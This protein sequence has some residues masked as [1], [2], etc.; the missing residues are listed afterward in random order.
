MN[1][2]DLSAMNFDGGDH[3]YEQVKRRIVTGIRSGEWKVG[4]RLPSEV[5]LVSE[6][7]VS[8]MTINRAYRE[9]AAEGLI[10]RVPAKGSFVAPARAR[11]MLFELRDVADEI[12]V[13]GDEYRCQVVVKEQVAVPGS[14]PT[15]DLKGASFVFHSIV[16]HHR[17]GDPIQ[18]EERWV[19]PYQA[20]EYL[21]I[22]FQ[23]T[24]A[25]QYLSR[26]GTTEMEHVVTAV[27]PDETQQHLLDVKA[28]EPC[29]L[30]TRRTWS[31]G[32]FIALSCL[33]SPGGRYAIRNRFTV[34]GTS[35]Q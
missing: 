3:L 21:D 4:Q 14:I 27:T 11:T 18:L 13:R 5:Q 2:D 25:F 26:L 29:L 9:L 33:M 16:V 6:L 19:N 24:S 34:A 1:K 28:D 12:R 10:I 23:K 20:P 15:D 30:L 22:D 17:N 32:E 31:N 35:A 7:N 8:R